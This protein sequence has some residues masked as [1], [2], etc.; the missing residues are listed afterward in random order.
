M[1]GPPHTGGPHYT[2]RVCVGIHGAC[3]NF[4]GPS[5]TYMASPQAWEHT[6]ILLSQLLFLQSCTWLIGVQCCTQLPAPC[7]FWGLNP[8]LHDG[9]TWPFLMSHLSP[10]PG[11]YSLA[12]LFRSEDCIKR[13][14]KFNKIRT[15]FAV[16]EI[17][18]L[19]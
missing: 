10:D 15:V 12:V 8:D 18:R 4:I 13:C 3:L 16:A 14:P 5:L 17:Y 2:H 11:G 1:C 6:G 9:S 7:G 19:C